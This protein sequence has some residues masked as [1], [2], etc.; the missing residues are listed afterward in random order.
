MISK[1]MVTAILL[2]PGVNLQ[3]AP[4]AVAA[5]RHNDVGIRPEPEFFPLN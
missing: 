2:P 4:E 5:V 1:Y 3:N